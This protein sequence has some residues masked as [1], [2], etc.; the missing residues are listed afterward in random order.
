MTYTP[1]EQPNSQFGDYKKINDHYET[2]ISLVRMDCDYNLK[3]DMEG[4]LCFDRELVRWEGEDAITTS[5]RIVT[6]SIDGKIIIEMPTL[7]KGYGRYGHKRELDTI[8]SYLPNSV[9]MYETGGNEKKYLLFSPDCNVRSSGYS[10]LV[11]WD[12]TK[13]TNIKLSPDGSVSGAKRVD[14]GEKKF[15]DN[16]PLEDQLEEK[17]YREMTKARLKSDL[18]I[19]YTQQFATFRGCNTDT[20]HYCLEMYRPSIYGASGPNSGLIRRLFVGR[21]MDNGNDAIECKKLAIEII[22]NLPDSCLTDKF[23]RFRG[24]AS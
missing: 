21:F 13:S 16:K 20:N 3:K 11:V 24:E 5:E 23:K 18:E 10:P 17:H 8:L 12:M 4:N 9:G 1:Y 22:K 7:K 2:E 6:Y 15:A 14:R 19:D